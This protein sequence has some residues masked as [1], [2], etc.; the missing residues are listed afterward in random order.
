[1]RDLEGALL[2]LKAFVDFSKLDNLN[3]TKE[4]IDVALG[5]IIK[6]KTKNININDI[7]K[8]S[9][10]HYGI[11]LSDLISKNRKQH[12]IL[13]RQMAIFI[14]H[15]TTSLSLSKI[16]KHFGNKDHSTV[17]HAIKR[18]KQRMEE[19]SEIRDEYKLLKL[20]LTNL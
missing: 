14:A 19:E 9:A 18:I 13:A 16:G 20:K 1:V 12:I 5:D 15:E 4:I 2:K 8:E 3:I 17:F 10:K 7:Q 6:P 11:T